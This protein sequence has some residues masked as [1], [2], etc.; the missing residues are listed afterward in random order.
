MKNDKIFSKFICTLKKSLQ[1]KEEIDG[2]K[3]KK[4][5]AD[6]WLEVVNFDHLKGWCLNNLYETGY[7]TGY[8][9]KSVDA[10]YISNIDTLIFIKFKSCNVNKSDI[11][12]KVSDSIM[13]YLD[14]EDEKLSDFR[15]R[16]EFILVGSEDSREHFGGMLEEKSF[17]ERTGHKIKLSRSKRFLFC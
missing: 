16:A 12:R 1:Y 11:R 6:S 17:Q 4:Y 15:A 10:L 9:L 3:Y 14:Y 5:M 8:E 13:I 7:P 2:K